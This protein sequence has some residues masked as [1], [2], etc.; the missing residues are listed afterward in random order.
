MSTALELRFFLT[1]MR[2]PPVICSIPSGLAAPEKLRQVVRAADQPPLAPRGL[3]PAP[4]EAVAAANR[5]DLSEDRF[6]GLAPQPVQRAAALREQL[7][8][9]VRER[10]A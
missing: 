5:L 6:D 10:E 2:F 8:R 9:G 4:H 3:M 7:A 1:R